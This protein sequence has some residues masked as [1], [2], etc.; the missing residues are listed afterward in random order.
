MSPIGARLPPAEHSASAPGGGELL[1]AYRVH[2][3]G[4]AIDAG[5]RWARL[6]AARG[7]PR[8]QP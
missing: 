1:E 6:G 8:Q 4:L 5:S 3:A 2:V 7:L